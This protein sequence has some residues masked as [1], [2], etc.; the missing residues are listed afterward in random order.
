M[1]A[2]ILLA[3]LG[4]LALAYYLGSWM[5]LLIAAGVCVVLVAAFFVFSMAR[6]EARESKDTQRAMG[7]SSTFLGGLF[8][9]SKH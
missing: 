4:V 9:P 1:R 5:G 6:L 7:R 2:I 8:H 3:N